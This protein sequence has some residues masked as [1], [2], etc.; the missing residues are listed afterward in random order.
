M[1]LRETSLWGIFGG[2]GISGGIIISFTP[3]VG[4]EIVVGVIHPF[5]I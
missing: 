5:V 2:V 4:L 1:A 3:E